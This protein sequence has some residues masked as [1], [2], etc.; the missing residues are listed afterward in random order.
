MLTLY[1]FSPA[2]RQNHTRTIVMYWKATDFY[3]YTSLPPFAKAI[4]ETEKRP[5]TAL[6]T[7]ALHD[8][9]LHNN[10]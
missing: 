7:I 10:V 8:T 1:G 2:V 3:F 5:K 6:T 4:W 9:N